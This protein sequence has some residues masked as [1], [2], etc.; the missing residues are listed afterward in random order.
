MLLLELS[1]TVA[2]RAR[3]S[4]PKI[5]ALLLLEERKKIAA[6]EMQDN[7]SATSAGSELKSSLAWLPRL[8]LPTFKG[9]YL[10]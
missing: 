10:Q 9:D 3:C 8:R 4:N 2:F 1:P 5:Y 6:R 7:F